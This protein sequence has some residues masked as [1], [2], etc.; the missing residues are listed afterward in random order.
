M[1]MSDDTE[2]I[3][4]NEGDENKAVVIHEASDLD[5]LFPEKNQY[6][7]ER[8]GSKTRKLIKEGGRYTDDG[9]AYLD[10]K[11]LPHIFGTDSAGARRFY[12]DLDDDDRLEQGSQQMASVASVNKELSERLQEP[13]D[14]VVKERLRDAEACINAFRDAPKL[15]K[16]RNIEESNIRRDLPKLKDKK[17]K[18]ENLTECQVTGEPLG[19]DAEAHHMDRKADNPRRARDLDNIAIVNLEAHRTIHKEGANSREELSK[20]CKEIGWNDPSKN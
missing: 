6:I 3:N 4:G 1:K 20:L 14:V 15:E 10:R 2:D 18:K 11:S 13:R 19:K 7:S 9:R 5:I 16:I 8:E 17:V 12:N